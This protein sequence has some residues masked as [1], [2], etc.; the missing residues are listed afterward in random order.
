MPSRTAAARTQ[1]GWAL[2]AH[3]EA[4]HLGIPVREL[5]EPC[6]EA[7]AARARTRSRGAVR[8]G[9]EHD[10]S[11]AERAADTVRS[12]SGR[13]V[14]RERIARLPANR[15]DSLTKAQRR[16]LGVE[17][18]ARV[19]RVL[20]RVVVRSD[21][22]RCRRADDH[23]CADHTGGERTQPSPNPRSHLPQTRSSELRN[24][25]TEA[26]RCYTITPTPPT[27]RREAS[28][29][30]REPD[31]RQAGRS[32]QRPQ[33]QRQPSVSSSPAVLSATATTRACRRG[34]DARSWSAT[35]S[36]SD[37]SGWP[38]YPSTSVAPAR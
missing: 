30:R 22:R 2:V 29:H 18:C 4:A 34:S 37:G 21:V 38:G 19:G 24:A 20:A 35:S 7:R 8:I 17:R 6:A 13:S 36:A 5:R 31:L 14:E 28:P 25:P 15:D 10:S 11:P 23:E 9:S 16:H 32:P 3:H 1:A 12:R 33:L 27:R 26:R